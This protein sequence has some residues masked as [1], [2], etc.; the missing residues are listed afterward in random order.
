MV[1]RTIGRVV[2]GLHE[3]SA[4]VP[5]LQSIG[6]AHSKFGVSTSVFEVSLAGAGRVCD[7]PLVLGFWVW[8]LGFRV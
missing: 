3:P 1:F 2:D 7:L 6:V 8:V 5:E 4:I